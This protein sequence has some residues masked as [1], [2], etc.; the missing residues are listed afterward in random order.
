MASSR[1]SADDLCML[2]T[3]GVLSRAKNCTAE[4]G[5]RAHS[6]CLLFCA[7]L[8]PAAIHG[9]GCGINVRFANRVQSKK[10]LLAMYRSV[11]GTAISRSM[12][13]SMKASHEWC[14]AHVEAR[15]VGVAVRERKLPDFWNRSAQS[16]TGMTDE[17]NLPVCPCCSGSIDSCT[18]PNGRCVNL[19][20]KPQ[21]LTFR[22]APFLSWG[23][24]RLVSMPNWLELRR[25]PWSLSWGWV[26]TLPAVYIL[27]RR[28]SARVSPGHCADLGK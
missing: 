16:S 7:P 23:I 1:S 9:P 13:Q 24:M 27:Y 21:R 15:Y 8:G 20:S 26:T 17:F 2:C 10:A 25:G 5:S 12:A 3:H 28:H 4:R 22:R 14:E 18:R 11:G 6:P 19:G